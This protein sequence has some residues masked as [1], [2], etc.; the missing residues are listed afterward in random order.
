MAVDEAMR[1][2]KA[3]FR[4]DRSCIDQI[5]TLRTTEW[6]SSLYMLFVDFEKAFD[7]LDRKVMWKILRH[8]GIPD[9]VIN[10]TK[11]QYQNFTCQVFHGG[12]MTQPIEVSET[13]MSSF[14]V[15][16]P[17]VIDWIRTGC[18]K[19]HI[20]ED[21]LDYSGHWTTPRRLGLFR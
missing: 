15:V 4:K 2:G 3:G 6:S 8:C 12:T 10:V 17:F 13:G 7:S 18:L 9:K 5:A 19:T 16:V 14:A 20:R 1:D 11:V 21:H